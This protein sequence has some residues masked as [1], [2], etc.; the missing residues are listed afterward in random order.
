MSDCLSAWLAF[1]VSTPFLLSSGHAFPGCDPRTAKTK[2]QAEGKASDS[3]RDAMPKRVCFDIF[4]RS[5]SVSCCRCY[6]ASSNGHRLPLPCFQDSAR[7]G[8]RVAISSEDR[9]GIP[10]QSKEERDSESQKEREERV[11]RKKGYFSTRAK[12]RKILPEQAEGE[13]RQVQLAGSQSVSQSDKP[14]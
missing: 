10:A 14:T 8:G 4:Q 9:K 3:S 11:D 2:T 1:S 5:A 13:R 12:S 7:R 6:V